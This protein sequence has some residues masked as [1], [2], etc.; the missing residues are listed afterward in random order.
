MFF[1]AP[2]YKH[3]VDRTVEI[4]GEAG[5]KDGDVVVSNHPYEAG[6]PHVSDMAFIAPIFADG[7]LIGFSG[8][9]AHK[10]DIGG[11]N[12]GSTSANST[13]IYHEGL[14]LP[15]VKISAEGTYDEDRSSAARCPA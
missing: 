9:C 2:F 1:H 15:P 14:V 4:Y 11:M 7:K 3:F 8:S 5:L 12:P 13:E 10:A 6:V